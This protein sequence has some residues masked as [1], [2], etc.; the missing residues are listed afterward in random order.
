MRRYSLLCSVAC[1]SDAVCTVYHDRRSISGVVAAAAAVCARLHFIF[2]LS[3]HP[4][5]LT[6][7]FAKCSP[8]FIH[9]PFGSISHRVQS[10]WF[11]VLFSSPKEWQRRSKKIRFVC[12]LGGLNSTKKRWRRVCDSQWKWDGK[13]NKVSNRQA[14]IW[15]RA[16]VCEWMVRTTLYYDIFPCVQRAPSSTK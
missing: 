4:Y 2:R 12:M 11:S 13:S 1:H 7:S 16:K 15:M 8:R 14:T 5:L 10:L 3:I 6:L 9:L